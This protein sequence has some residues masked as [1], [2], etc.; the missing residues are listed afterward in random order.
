M[1]RTAI[2]VRAV[3]KLLQFT[4]LWRSRLLNTGGVFFSNLNV[5]LR[6]VS[7]SLETAFLTENASNVFRPHHTGEI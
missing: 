3:L 5:S 2:L 1:L 7:E 6:L 4:S